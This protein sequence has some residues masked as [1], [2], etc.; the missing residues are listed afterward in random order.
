[1]SCN[2]NGW[3]CEI[4]GQSIDGRRARIVTSSVI[5]CVAIACASIVAPTIRTVAGSGV[6]G[7]SG[8]NGPAVEAKLNQPFDVAIGSDG[9]SR[10]QIIS[11]SRRIRSDATMDS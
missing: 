3:L 10:C 9:S 8:D 6:Q 4:A 7:Y 1:M 2:L 11:G 5:A